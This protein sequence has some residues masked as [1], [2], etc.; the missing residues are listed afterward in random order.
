MILVDDNAVKEKG[1][2]SFWFLGAE[3][4]SFWFLVSGSAFMECVVNQESKNQKLETRNYPSSLLPFSPSP[5]LPFSPSPLLSCYN[6]ARC[7][8]YLEGNHVTAKIR[9]HAW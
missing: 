7:G 2:F 9:F 3:V 1:G 6:A 5:S 8:N 4:S